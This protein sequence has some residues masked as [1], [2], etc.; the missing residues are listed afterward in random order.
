[1]TG[2]SHMIWS[3]DCITRG[4][5]EPWTHSSPSHSFRCG[6]GRTRGTFS[7][8]ELGALSWISPTSLE[9]DCQGTRSSRRSS[10]T[11]KELSL[12]GGPHPP[13][14]LVW[15]ES[16]GVLKCWSSLLPWSV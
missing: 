13:N 15:A 3:C 16:A 2:L 6:S 9:N 7:H 10:K 4:K 14:P 8:R 5:G 12:I 1:M 11:A